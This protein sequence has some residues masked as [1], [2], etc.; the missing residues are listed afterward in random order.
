MSLEQVRKRYEGRPEPCK[1]QNCRLKTDRLHC[2]T[3]KAEKRRSDERE[4][5]CDCIVFADYGKLVVC[6][7]ELKSGRVNPTQVKRQLDAGAKFAERVCTDYLDGVRP[8]M[9]PIL[10]TRSLSDEA[11]IMLSVTEVEI[12]GKTRALIHE[13]CNTHISDIIKKWS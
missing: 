4:S 8:G 12:Y 3:I 10:L 11:R 9:L 2:V 1:E 13:K 7:C 5:M 6:V